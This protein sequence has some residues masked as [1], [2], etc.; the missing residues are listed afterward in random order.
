MEQFS[1]EVGVPINCTFPVKNY[2]RKNK[3]N[4]DVDSLILDA[5][6]NIL[7]FGR[8]YLELES[9]DENW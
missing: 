7:N 2:H 5:L 6:K 3:M 1:K 4:S 8:D 9:S